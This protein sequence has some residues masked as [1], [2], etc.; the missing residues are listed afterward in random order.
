MPPTALTK[1]LLRAPKGTQVNQVL[2]RGLAIIANIDG[3]ELH[4]SLSYADRLPT[5]D[6]LKRVKDLFWDPNAEV[7]QVLPPQKEYVND[8]PFCLH[9]WGDPFG[10]KRY[11]LA[12]GAPRHLATRRV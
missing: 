12:L 4:V 2:P 3:E 10:V 9:L 11:S 1:E 6:D 8:H 7:I 5:W